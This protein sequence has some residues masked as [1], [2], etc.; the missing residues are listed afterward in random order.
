VIVDFHTHVFPPEMIA[1]REAIALR[2]PTFREMYGNPKAKMATADDLLRS[3]DAGGV[4]VSVVL[5][6]A[7]W[8]KDDC[9]TQND[10]VL[11]TA[12]KSRGRLIPFCTVEMGADYEY[13]AEVAHCA[14][15]GARGLGELRP[16]SQRE[17]TV[18]SWGVRLGHAASKHRQI[19]LFHAS[20]PVGHAYPGKK[21]QDI[22]SISVFAHNH[23]DVPIV[24]AHWGGGLPFYTLMPEVRRALA[25]TYYDTAASRLLYSPDVYRRA[26]DLVGADKVLFGSDFPLIDQRAARAEVEEAGLTPDEQSLVLGGNA[27]RLL[28]LS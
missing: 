4:D 9:R 28:G 22:N 1:A 20:E 10:Y 16:L 17:L 18:D 26:A 14:A 25:N 23:P 12:L 2:D 3:M 8:S 19:L 6:F 24:A 5:G 27:D 13:P 21:G 15:L 7:W 11:D